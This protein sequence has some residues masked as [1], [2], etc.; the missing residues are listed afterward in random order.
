MCG[1]LIQVVGIIYGAFG[2]IL[3]VG[4]PIWSRVSELLTKEKPLYRRQH[5][6]HV[7]CCWHCLDV[8]RCLHRPKNTASCPWTQTDCSEV[9]LCCS[10]FFC[11]T[12]WLVCG[13]RQSLGDSCAHTM[14]FFIFTHQQLDK[15]TDYGKYRKI[16][17]YKYSVNR[18]LFNNCVG[19]Y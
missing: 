17:F 3:C 6:R 10:W 5:S 2:C 4:L 12:V 1:W 13:R 18:K 16:P 11:V 9:S 14:W 8:L 7:L 19:R 15:I